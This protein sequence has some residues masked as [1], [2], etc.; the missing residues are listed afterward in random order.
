MRLKGGPW[1]TLV[2]VAPVIG[3]V[4]GL[5]IGVA[6]AITTAAQRS[7]AGTRSAA[8]VAGTVA[9]VGTVYPVNVD[10]LRRTYRAYRGAAPSQPVGRL[11]LLIVL[12]GRGQSEQAAANQTGFLGLARQGRVVLVFPDG[13][14]RSWNAGH[15]CCGVAGTAGIPDVPF[16]AAVVADALRRWPVD[17]QRVYLVGYSNGGKLAYRTVCAHPK[18]FAA[19][20]TYGAV[21]LV[22]CTSASAAVPFLLAVGTADQILPFYGRPAGHPPLPA[23]PQALTWL[24]RQDGCTDRKQTGGDGSAIVQW[25]AGC[26]GDAEVESVVYPGRGHAW[27]GTG[28]VGQPAAAATLMWTFLSR[29]HDSAARLP[30][31]AVLG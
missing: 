5:V 8:T 24:R 25:W 22:P 7:F 3:L 15:G 18:L 30:A 20:A 21:P 27:P 6:A 2:T 11:P 12:H 31:H 14:H 19:V 26:A 4:I 13:R 16:V 17:V 23:V 28:S 10:G 1:R 29:H 9:P